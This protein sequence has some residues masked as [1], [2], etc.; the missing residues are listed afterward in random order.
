MSE[1]AREKTIQEVKI[2]LL[3]KE[4]KLMFVDFEKKFKSLSSNARAKL[5][6]TDPVISH[7]TFQSKPFTFS[8]PCL[9]QQGSEGLNQVS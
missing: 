9:P 3:G 6:Q 4:P 2:C 7:K 8:T 5:N 1:K